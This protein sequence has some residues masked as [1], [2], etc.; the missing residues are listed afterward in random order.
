MARSSILGIS[1]R[2]LTSDDMISRTSKCIQSVEEIGNSKQPIYEDVDPKSIRFTAFGD[3][4]DE[5]EYL[6]PYGDEIVDQKIEEIDDVYIEA[7]NT[8]IGTQVVVPGKDYIPVLTTVKKRK[9][10]ASGNLVGIANPNPILD[11]R[12][13]EL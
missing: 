1:P 10:D 3:E 7:L 11:T 2:D 9:R 4:R 6:L 5:D 12:I 13:Y 8:Y